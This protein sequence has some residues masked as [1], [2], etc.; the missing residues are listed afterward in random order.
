MDITI[1]NTLKLAISWKALTVPYMRE[2]DYKLSKNWLS[3]DDN[4]SLC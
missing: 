1:V 3:H 4:I 2:I